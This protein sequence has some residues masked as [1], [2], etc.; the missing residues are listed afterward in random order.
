MSFNGRPKL[1]LHWM[2]AATPDLPREASVPQICILAL[3]G[4]VRRALMSQDIPF[5]L[6]RCDALGGA[7]D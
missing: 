4:T 5:F 1:T 6:K 3:T 7:H 2:R